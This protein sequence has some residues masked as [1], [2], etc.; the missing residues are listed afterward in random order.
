MQSNFLTANPVF[1][2]KSI[3]VNEILYNRTGKFRATVGEPKTGIDFIPP[4]N[5]G[6]INYSSVFEP[7]FRAAKVK[8]PESFS[9][10]NHSDVQKYYPNLD[11]HVISPVLDQK[12]CGSCWAFAT[13]SCVADRWAIANN[14]P[15]PIFSP[16]FLLSCDELENGCQGGFINK[17]LS[18]VNK[19][20]AVKMS[21][22]DYSWCL[23]NNLC[24]VGNEEQAQTLLPKCSS[25]CFDSE[26][27]QTYKTS[28]WTDTVSN[29]GDNEFDKTSKT[30]KT[31]SPDTI[32]DDIKEEIFLRGPVTIGFFVYEDFITGPQTWYQGK[33]GPIYASQNGS[34]GQN[35]GGHAVVIVGWGVDTYTDGSPLPYWIIRNSWSTTWG[36]QGYFKAAMYNEKLGINIKHGFDI[37]LSTPNGDFGGVFAPLVLPLKYQPKDDKKPVKDNSDG[38]DNKDD[39]KSNL[40]K[41]IIGGVVAIFIILLLMMIL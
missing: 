36:D 8:V 1:S 4:L 12:H 13:S 11:H 40:W 9:W 23:N 25:S 39:K 30:F 28:K 15:N 27:F 21:C 29:K 3:K 10:N 20:G 32:I 33:H 14:K 18:F 16:T 17:A 2:N 24:T 26:N 34:E 6:L 22:Q 37:H 38:D 19:K 35:N 31:G 41:W 7:R 5:T